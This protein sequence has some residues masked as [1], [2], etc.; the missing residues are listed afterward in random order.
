MADVG[1]K[2]QTNLVNTWLTVEAAYQQALLSQNA[3][4]LNQ[5]QANF[6]AL[7]RRAQAALQAPADT[8]VLRISRS[9]LGFP[10][11]AN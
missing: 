7:Q 10:K 5:L 8:G 6:G 11:H 9:R 3:S 4:S 2:T 1:C